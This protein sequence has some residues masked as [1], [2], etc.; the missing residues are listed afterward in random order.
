MTLNTIDDNTSAL[1]FKAGGINYAIQLSYV[2]EMVQALPITAAPMAPWYIKGICDL[3]GKIIP[4]V[5]LS[6]FFHGECAF[7]TNYRCLLVVEVNDCLAGLLVDNVL[8]V[9]SLSEGSL[10][11]A[12]DEVSNGFDRYVD[13]TLNNNGDKILA[14]DIQKVFCDMIDGEA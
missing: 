11:E 6:G 9:V 14:I 3:R 7:E 4:V 13:K 10:L 8:E 2:V 12:G 1:A 5:D